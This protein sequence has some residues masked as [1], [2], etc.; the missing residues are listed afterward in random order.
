MELKSIQT[1]TEV[2]IED[3]TNGCYRISCEEIE[4]SK[5]IWKVSCIQK[6]ITYNLKCFQTLVEKIFEAKTIDAK[7]LIFTI[8]EMDNASIRIKKDSSITN[9][10]LEQIEISF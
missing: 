4:E 5:K 8:K 10:L 9:Q 2:L 7:E 3:S 6:S 1:V